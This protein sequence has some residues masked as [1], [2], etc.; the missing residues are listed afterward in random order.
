MTQ[1]QD[2]VPAIAFELFN[3]ETRQKEAVFPADGKVVRLYT[4]GP[5]VYDFAHIG[6]FRTFV[7]EDVLKRALCF[8]GMKVVH[9]MNLTDVDDKTIRGAIQKNISLDAF[10]K[11]F[12]EAFFEDLKTLNVV[13][14]DH[15]PEA[16][17][18]IPKM[19][20]II[21]ELMRQ[22]VAYKGA[23]GSIYFAIA[24]FPQYGRLSHLK[25]DSLQPSIADRISLDE[26]S[27]EHISDFVLWKMYDKERDGGIFWES[28]FGPGRPGWHIECSA[29]AQ[30][31]LGDSIDIHAGGVDLIF[32]HHENEIAQSEACNHKQFARIWTHAEHLLVDQKKMSKSLG[33]FY[34]LRD[35][36]QKGYSGRVIRF[37]LVQTHYRTQLN[38]T[39]QG[40]DA[41]KAS[42]Q[43][44][45]DFVFRLGNY[46]AVHASD[47]SIDQY[48]AQALKAFSEAIADDLNTSEA[49]ATLFD[50]V[51]HVNA[52]QDKGELT[53]K[54][55][56]AVFALLKKFDVVLGIFEFQKEG[57][58][59]EIQ[60]LVQARNDAR[61]GKNWKLSDELRGALM[62]KGYSVEDTPEGT[63][64]K[65]MSV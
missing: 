65:K 21:E 40:L 17:S 15:Y 4:C 61:A 10:T 33:N 52:L 20:E 35:L 38:F 11:P 34:T 49:L 1:L 41:A 22:S 44:L 26:Y 47:R 8:F 55:R 12:K 62:Q 6:N 64:V 46:K 13:F 50:L 53:E 27:K 31:L 2:N 24:K 14:A 42:L 57:I 36:L 43:R 59:E 39:L 3:T 25:L 9:V 29:M 48:L 28:P 58:S 16:V 63:R 30:A 5:T 19:I 60:A 7:F 18:Y 45:D 32:P 37:L 56:D 23:D 51:R 54:D